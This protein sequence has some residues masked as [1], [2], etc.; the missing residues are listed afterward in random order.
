MWSVDISTGFLTKYGYTYNSSGNLV[1]TVTQNAQP[2]AIAG[3]QT[4]TYTYDLLSRL[5]SESN[6]ETGTISY[7]YDTDAT[8][9]TSKGDLVKK[10]DAANNVS[11]YAYDARHRVTGITY[12]SGPYSASTPS[13]SFIYDATTFSCAPNPAYPNGAYVKG[14]LAE[15]YTGPSNPKTTDIAYCYSPRGEIADEFETTP[16]SKTTYHTTASYWAN[17]A[18]HVLSGVASR[19]AW[20]FVVDGEGRPN[21]AVDGTS[22]NLVTATT[23]NVAGQPTG[24]TLGSGDSDTYT[25]D[26]NTNRMKTYEFNIGSTPKYVT[27]T[28]GWNPNW[29]LGSLVITDA[30]NSANAQNCGYTYDDLSR[31]QSVECGPHNPDGTTWGQT[32]SYDAFGNISKSGTSSFRDRHYIGTGNTTTNQYYQLP[33]G[34][35]GVSNYYDL[36]GNLTTDL[37]NTYAWDADGNTIGINLNNSNP[38]INITYDAFDRIRGREQIGNLHASLV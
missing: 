31:L 8:C 3:T 24:V 4:R 13:K 2:G 23:Y 17:G 7:V 27:G 11:C 20:T 25:Y 12:P 16:N 14:R 1:Y 5:V 21:T 22:T 37:T 10:V 6:P 18:L 38:P 36:N 26:A 9:G 33:S 32:F 34:P 29:T 15:A 28:L 35:T 19:N 30:F